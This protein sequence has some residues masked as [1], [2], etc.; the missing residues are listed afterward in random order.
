MLNDNS[1]PAFIAENDQNIEPFKTRKH[2]TCK[3]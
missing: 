3:E 1:I 2:V